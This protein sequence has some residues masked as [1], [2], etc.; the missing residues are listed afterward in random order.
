MPRTGPVSTYF[1][2]NMMLSNVPKFFFFF[3]FCSRHIGLNW[4]NTY[5]LVVEYDFKCD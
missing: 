3:V 4:S 5:M 2:V 1:H